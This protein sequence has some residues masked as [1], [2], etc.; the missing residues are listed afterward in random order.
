[1]I[2]HF[3]TSLH[4]PQISW[5]LLHETVSEKLH[6]RKLCSCW[7]PKMLTDE[8]KMKRGMLTRGVVMLYDDNARPHTAPALEDLVVTFGLEQFDHRTYSTDLAPSDVHVFLHLKT[9]LH[10][11]QFHDE[12]K[13]ATCGL[14]RRRHHSTMQGYKNWCP[15]TKASTMVETISKSSVRYVHQ[16]S[17]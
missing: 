16:M 3:V 6:L 2:H 4:F 5:S 8:H 13:E 15:A 11:Q 9:F 10:G 17:I 1:M 14:H 12:V 7:V